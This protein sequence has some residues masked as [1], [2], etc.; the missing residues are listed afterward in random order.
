LPSKI[1]D[2][3][4]SVKW[5]DK[6]RQSDRLDRPPKSKNRTERKR[7]VAKPSI[8]RPKSPE[9]R[10]QYP[11]HPSV[12]PLSC[13]RFGCCCNCSCCGYSDTDFILAIISSIRPQTRPFASSFSFAAATCATFAYGNFSSLTFCA[14]CR[15]R[16]E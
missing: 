12:Y 4:M 9:P 11:V 2:K 15:C 10:T 1:N 5:I 16:F 6:P 13:Q 3:V 14:A 8:P 7:S